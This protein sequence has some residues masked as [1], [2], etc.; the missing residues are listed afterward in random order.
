MPWSNTKDLEGPKLSKKEEAEY[1]NYVRAKKKK[2]RFYVDA[3]VPRQ[4]VE[5]LREWGFNVLTAGEAGKKTHSDEDHLAEAR[6]Q[7]RI[8]VSCDR[9]YL[10]ER[11]YPIHENPIILAVCDFGT[12]TRDQIIATFQ[13]LDWIQFVGDYV[14]EGVKIDAKTSEWKETVRFQ[15]GYTRS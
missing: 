5:I 12:G 6:K 9:D 13:W 14:H 15:E 1:E 4:A 11:R 8:L 2:Q 10:I 7:R 3:D